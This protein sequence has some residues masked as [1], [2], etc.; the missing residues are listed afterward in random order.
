MIGSISRRT[1]STSMPVIKAIFSSLEIETTKYKDLN[2]SDTFHLFSLEKEFGISSINKAMTIIGNWI[3]DAPYKAGVITF[4]KKKSVEWNGLINIINDGIMAFNNDAASIEIKVGKDKI[5]Y[6][7]VI[8][9]I[10]TTDSPLT[11]MQ[12]SLIRTL[13]Q[14][15]G[16]NPTKDLTQ[17]I[18]SK[19][20]ES[21]LKMQSTLNTRIMNLLQL[22]RELIEV[23]R[24]SGSRIDPL[25]HL[26]FSKK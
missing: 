5:L 17:K 6:R 25:Y 8:G 16:F 19:N 11:E 4:T 3:G 9:E 18:G 24:Q 26:I 12:F 13:H 1:I 2:K 20:K 14:N 7:N 22:P 21:F 15:K 10:L 23:E